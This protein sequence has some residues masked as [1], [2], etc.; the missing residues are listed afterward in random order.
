MK[1]PVT[2][3]ELLEVESIPTVIVF[4]ENHPMEDMSSAFDGTYRVLFP[5]LAQRGITPTGPGFALYTDVP[6]DTVSFEVGIPVD[7][8][9]ESDITTDSG[10]VLKNSVIPGGK[11]ARI[12]HIGSFDGLSDSWPAFVEAVAVGGNE[13]DMPFW[14]V[15]VTEPSPDMDPATLQTDLY[16]RLK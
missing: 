8:P 13:L 15:Y 9:L 12:S 7:K 14:E 16:V 3:V 6:S 4:F 2:E 5:N 11:I 10:L 1:P